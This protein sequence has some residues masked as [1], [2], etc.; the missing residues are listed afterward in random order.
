MLLDEAIEILNLMPGQKVIDATL[1]LGGHT[2][3]ILKRIQPGGTLLAMDKDA[4]TLKKVMSE[5]KQENAPIHGVHRDYRHLRASM[6]EM[7]WPGVDAILLDAGVSSIHLDDPERGF[8]IKKDGPLD[9]RMDRTQ[10]LKASD[11]VNTWDESEIADLIYMNGEE[12]YSRRI[13][14]AIVHDRENKP[15][16]RTQE[17]SDLICRVVGKFYKKQKIHPATRTFQALR[18]IVNDELEALKEFLDQSVSCLNKQ[19]RLVII[20]FH[21]LEDRMV[22]NHFRALA[23]NHG[24]GGAPCIRILT[25]KPVG[26][27]H[28]E[29]ERNLRSRSAKLRALERVA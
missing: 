19:G 2:K 20:S 22:K 7:G 23:K 11:I 12:R 27:S 1:G 4:E 8:S 5:L 25:K 28:I 14:K 9:M 16:E 17:L 6:E 3:E 13:A 29:I 18:I 24:G 15:F 10:R 26:P 21:S